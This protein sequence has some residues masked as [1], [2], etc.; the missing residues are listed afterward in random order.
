MRYLMTIL[1]TF[2]ITSTLWAGLSYKQIGHK[3]KSSQWIYEAYE[4]K[5][6]LATGI[7]GVKVVIVSGSNSLFG[8]DSAVL[9]KA[10]TKPVINQSVHAGLGIRYIL[11]RS[12]RI[13]QQGDTVILPLEYSFY[14]SDGKPSEVYSDFILSRDTDYFYS[15]STIDQFMVISSIKPKRLFK[16]LKSS[17]NEELEST[18]G[19]YGVQNI[20][21]YGDQI[22]IEPNKMTAAEK[23]AVDNTYA[24]IISVSNLSD[25]FIDTMG[26]YIAWAQNNDICVIVM[27]PN[28]MFFAEYKDHRYTAFHTNIKSYFSNRSTPHIG[29]NLTYMYDKKY[30]FNT[31]YHLNSEGVKLRTNQ[32]IFDLGKSSKTLCGQP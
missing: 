21:N 13:L 26:S 28:Y 30:Y 19:I 12:K 7:K 22:N 25:Y 29:D 10:W 9:E 8:I 4:L 27:P 2:I 3:T 18:A 16:G 24:S 32:M 17:I 5:D 14:Q 15:L 23:S 11:N 6:A 1:S 31:K 20:N